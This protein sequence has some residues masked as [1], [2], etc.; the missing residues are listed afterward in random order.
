M[1]PDLDDLRYVASGLPAIALIVLFAA[2]R[3]GWILYRLFW[4]T[5]GIGFAGGLTLVV[6]LIV[7]I[8]LAR[9]LIAAEVAEYGNTC[10]SVGGTVTM[11]AYFVL[12][13]LG[14][15]VIYRVYSPQDPT[16]AKLMCL[17]LAGGSFM[18]WILLRWP[19]RE[20]RQLAWRTSRRDQ[21]ADQ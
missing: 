19:I 13:A 12:L 7:Q 16:M 14:A 21:E 15:V 17:T 4:V 6:A 18:P 2:W 10:L 9:K 5:F 1:R 8:R 3:G 20:I 11:L